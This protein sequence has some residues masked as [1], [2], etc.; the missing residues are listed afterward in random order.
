MASCVT[1]DKYLKFVPQCHHVQTGGNNPTL[2]TGS[3]TKL[4][5]MHTNAGGSGSSSGSD[6]S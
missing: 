1:L 6:K 3:N 2:K 4:S 5:T